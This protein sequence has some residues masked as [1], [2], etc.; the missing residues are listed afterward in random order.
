VPFGNEKQRSVCNNEIERIKFNMY[1]VPYV[2][3]SNDVR[4][5]FL[6]HVSRRRKPFFIFFITFYENIFLY[7]LNFKV[8][9]LRNISSFK[10]TNSTGRK[11]SN[12]KENNEEKVGNYDKIPIIMHNASIQYLTISLLHTTRYY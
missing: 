1:V 8:N 6:L 5:C 2:V 9:I 12:N 4:Y 11:E 7:F 3:M 10:M